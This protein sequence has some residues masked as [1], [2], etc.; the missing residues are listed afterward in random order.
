MSLSLGEKLQQAREARGVTI[1]EVA[2]QTRISAL[3]LQC[4]ENNDYRTLPGG[5]FNKGFVKSFAR[6]VGVDEQEALQD[7]NHLIVEQQGDQADEP[8][9]YKPEVLTDERNSSSLITIIF[10]VVILVLMTFGILKLVNYLQSEQTPAAA[11]NSNT[12][13]N[14][15]ANAANNSNTNTTVSTAPSLETAKIEFKAAGG[16]I[17]LTAAVDGKTSYP[18]V[19]D[20]KPVPFAPKENLKL[21]YAKSRAQFAQLTINGKQITLPAQPADPK[22]NAIDIEINKAN[23]GEIWQNGQLSSVAAS[24]TNT[25]APR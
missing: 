7:Y 22:R 15:T 25:G 14:A 10:A 17:S 24:N 23:I 18:L 13:S 19:T 20:G 1:S 12:N 2:E 8:K 21:S 3:Y 5:I 9:T 6:Y 11:N 16:D 4:I